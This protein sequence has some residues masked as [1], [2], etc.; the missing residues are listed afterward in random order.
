MQKGAS[1]HQRKNTI[2]I[3][4]KVLIKEDID[5]TKIN[6]RQ[7]LDNGFYKEGVGRVVRITANNLYEVQE[8]S[9][10]KCYCRQQLKVV[11]Q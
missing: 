2:E 3:G 9:T 1:V 7:K 8:G 4:N 6:K 5:T 11:E 10:S